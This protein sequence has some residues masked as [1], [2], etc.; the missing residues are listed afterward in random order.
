M[1]IES[2]ISL[3]KIGFHDL[4]LIRTA[5]LFLQIG[6]TASL[7]LFLATRRQLLVWLGTLMVY[8]HYQ[9]R[10]LT[11]RFTKMLVNWNAYLESKLD[12]DEKDDQN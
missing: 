1:P 9:R 12:K 3:I 8:L 7:L 4:Q 10:K 2:G 6:R 11:V 5:I